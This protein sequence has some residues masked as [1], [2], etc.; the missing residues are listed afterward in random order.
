MTS[1]WTLN[2]RKNVKNRN[3]RALISEYH[4]M[5]ADGRRE[6]RKELARRKVKKSVLPYKPKRKRSIGVFGFNLRSMF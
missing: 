6:T 2:I 1:T 4:Q 5:N 3:T